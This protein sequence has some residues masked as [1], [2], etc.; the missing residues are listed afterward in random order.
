MSSLSETKS[1]GSRCT[2][3]VGGDGGLISKSSGSL[4]AI[5]EDA[6]GCFFAAGPV[7]LTLRWR[8]EATASSSASPL[9]RFDRGG[10]D[11]AL[12]ELVASEAVSIAL[13]EMY[14]VSSIT[15]AEG[16]SRIRARAPGTR[17]VTGTALAP[18]LYPSD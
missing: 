14:M 8:F 1:E 18:S 11:S 7:S 13:L 5:D 4:T 2:T 16:S 3:P 17:G 12:N 15:V 10:A 9:W 6:A